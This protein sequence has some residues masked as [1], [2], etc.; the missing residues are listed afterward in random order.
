LTEREDELDPNSPADRENFGEASL[1]EAEAE[2]NPD[3]F[4][5]RGEDAYA[6]EEAA[7]EA[8]GEV[9]TDLPAMEPA[10]AEATLIEEEELAREEAGA[11]GGISGEEGL[12]EAERPLAEA[13][14]GESEGFEQ[15]EAALIEAASHGDPA[16]NPLGDR[17]TPEDAS[18]E[19]LAEYGEADHERVS[20]DK[21]EDN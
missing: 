4:D 5:E 8:D 16:G 18:S 15:S 20:E 9:I 13:G 10:P 6:E 19:G 14:E 3:P 11:I 7:A 1:G 12:P 21:N 17:F 2:S